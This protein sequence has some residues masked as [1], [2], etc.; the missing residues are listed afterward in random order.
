MGKS[1]LIMPI[2]IAKVEMRKVDVRRRRETSSTMIF[3]VLGLQRDRMQGGRLL[4]YILRHYPHLLCR[5]HSKTF[6]MSRIANQ[7]SIRKNFIIDGYL[8]MGGGLFRVWWAS[9]LGGLDCDES[10]SGIPGT[11]LCTVPGRP[12][13]LPDRSIELAGSAY[14][15]DA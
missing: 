7:L 10:D 1:L 5:Y 9:S 3:L 12:K 14:S 8:I 4:I 15:C 11:A 2:A 13:A 6:L